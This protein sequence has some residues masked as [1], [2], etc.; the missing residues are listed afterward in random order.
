MN[1]ITKEVGLILLSLM[2]I[3]L[4]W[5]V[6]D[7][8]PER[9]ATHFDING[10]PNGWSSKTGFISMAGFLGPGLYLLLLFLPKFDP[11]K[12]LTE[13]GN[14]YYSLRLILGVFMSSILVYII[15]SSIPGNQHSFNFVFV[16]LGAL[17]AVLGNYFQTIRPNYFIGIRTPWTLE[18]T[19]VWN[20][21]HRLA[22]KLWLIGGL[23]SILLSFV[24]PN[25]L[26]K[27][28]FIS[29]VIVITLVPVVHSYLEFKKIKNQS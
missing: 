26:F 10:E 7:Q 2:P 28:V 18:S 9:I 14:K 16:A 17:F 29:I 27:V 22:G 12:R 13:M 5:I 15:Y 19:E 25:D 1:K 8:L 11:K 6:W 21:T 24:I 23:L 4:I 20:S 3:V